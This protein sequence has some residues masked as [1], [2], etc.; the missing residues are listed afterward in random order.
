MTF[1]STWNI[2]C[3]LGCDGRVDLERIAAGLRKLG[4]A[5]VICLQEVARHMPG[6]DQGAGADQAKVLTD[7]FPDYESFFGAA[8]NLEGERPTQRGQFGNLILS[9]LPVAQVFTHPLPQKPDPAVKHM[10][11]QV[12]EVVVRTNGKALR[13]M[14]THLEYHSKQQREQQIAKVRKLH[15]QNCA[16]VRS[17]GIDPAKAPMH[18]RNALSHWSF[19][20]ISTLPK[21]VWNTNKCWPVL[22]TIHR[23]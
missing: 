17:P 14:T 22:M 1:I 18:L 9:R 13:V 11:R 12:T 7:L 6:L 20:G 23:R 8:I 19:V 3:G 2:Q 16:N 4:E 5:D 21:P 15:Q 10:P